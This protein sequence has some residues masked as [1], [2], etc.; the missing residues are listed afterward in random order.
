VYAKKHKAPTHKSEHTSHLTASDF[1]RN[2][3][4]QNTGNK[5][6]IQTEAQSIQP[7]ENIPAYQQVAAA[8]SDSAKTTESAVH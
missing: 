6:E 4:F 7:G 1:Q 8:I 3:N 2:K 5:L